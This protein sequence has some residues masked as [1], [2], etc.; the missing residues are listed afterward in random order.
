M[1]M[2]FIYFH[3]IDDIFDEMEKAESLLLSSTSGHDYFK[4][5]VDEGE[6]GIFMDEKG[7]TDKQPGKILNHREKDGE[8]EL[9]MKWYLSYDEST[10]IKK[11]QYKHLFVVMYIDYINKK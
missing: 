4:V 7:L 11:D 1:K 8:L 3:S 9:L 5:K 2:I 6:K 10:W